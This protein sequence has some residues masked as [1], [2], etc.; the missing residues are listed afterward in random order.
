MH[1]LRSSSESTP[2]IDEV[3]EVITLRSGKKVEQPVPKPAE[4]NEGEPEKI[5]IKDDAV[6]K[7][8]PP[9]FLQALKGKKKD[10]NQV[11]ILEVP[12]RVK[13]S[14]PLLDMIKQVPT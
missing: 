14:I 6:K 5:E 10:I 1:E 12:R 13:I 2:R 9:P 4:E 11:E 7:S 8:T 3:K